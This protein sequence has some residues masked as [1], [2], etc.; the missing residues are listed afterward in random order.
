MRTHAPA[1]GIAVWLARRYAQRYARRTL[2]PGRAPRAPLAALGI[3][4]TALLTTA[5]LGP[6]AAV[7]P[8]PGAPPL[9][10]HANPPAALVTALL[11]VVV[12]AGGYG[13][14]GCLAALRRGWAL[15]V[16]WLFGCSVLVAVALGVLAPVGSTDAASYAAYGRL[17][18][19][20]HDPYVTSPNALTG[21]FGDLAEPPWQHTPSVYGPLATGE[22]WIA[23]KLAG[24]GPHAPA[25]AVFALGLFN[26]VAFVAIG[27]ALQFLAAGQAGRRRAAVF[28][29]ANPLLLFEGVAGAHVDVFATLLVV[30]GLLALRRSALGGALAAGVA[31][32][33]AAAVKASAA[34]AGLAFA[35]ASSANRRAATELV[36]LAAGAAAV[37]VPAYLLAGPHVFD[38]LGR[39][40]SFV[41]FADPW[42]IITY[43]LE[44][45]FGHDTA[46][47]VIRVLAWLAFV[48]FA[49]MLD[50]G[51]PGRH[52]SYGQLTDRTL[53]A[54]RS[55]AVLVIAWLLTAPY[56]LPWYAILAFATLTLLPPSG[57]DRL[58][59]FWI[60]V[61][62]I[63]YLPGRQ[64]TLPSGFAGALDVWKSGFTPVL[65]AATALAAFGLSLRTRA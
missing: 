16:R 39:A 12:I 17:A 20:G 43:P 18:A 1:A 55:V 14:A 64:V 44:A 25:Y 51:L 7:L 29:S 3:S 57:F 15:R 22:Q 65:L 34:L 8:L 36:A 33:A 58:M 30:A 21:A 54:A 5:A 27:F 28:F 9:G 50:R 63:A 23:A 59:M 26:A 4:M 41:S 60:S 38:Q 32:G 11:A 24:D 10:W 19:T 52:R 35:W 31:G 62:A 47:L 37:L 46:R 42:R 48:V 40:S 45:A 56:V 49:V 53:S 2:A 6:S 13:V 61:L